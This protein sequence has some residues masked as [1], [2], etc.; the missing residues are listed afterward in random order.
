MHPIAS[1]GNPELVRITFNH[2]VC[3]SNILRYTP[4]KWFWR[5]YSKTGHSRVQAGRSARTPFSWLQLASII[6][7]D[8]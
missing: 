4:S 1:D 5:R 7:Y 2:S 6:L 8:P 3:Q